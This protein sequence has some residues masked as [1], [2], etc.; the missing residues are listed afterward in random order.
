[1]KKYRCLNFIGLGNGILIFAMFLGEP[2][3]YTRHEMRAAA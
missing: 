1:M 3:Q 2:I